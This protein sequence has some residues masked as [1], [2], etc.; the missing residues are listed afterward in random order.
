M[1]SP[2]HITVFRERVIELIAPRGG[3]LYVD[4]TLGLG[5][6]SEAILEASQPDGRVVCI[7]RDPTAIARSKARLARFGDRAEFHHA[8]M[9]SVRSVLDGRLVDGLVADLGVSSPQLD[10]PERGMS[11]RAEGPLD[12]RMDLDGEVTAWS[13]VRDLRESDLA[14]VIYQ[15]GEERRSRPIA[16]SIKRAI[17][18][19]EMET[20]KQLAS[21]IYRVMGPPRF[22]T[23]DPATRTFQALRIAVNDELGEL[24][25]LLAAV[26]DV[27]ADGGVAAIISF[28]SLE[29]RKVKHAFRDADALEV[30]TKKPIEPGDDECRENPRARSAKLR[31]ARRAVRDGEEEA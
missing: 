21:A 29:D 9:S 4:V 12:M 2:L 11:F 16:R 10:E 7:D 13:L 3:G 18:A 27:L 6:H 26:P 14:D 5:G 24:D 8:T 1:E 23:L 22:G 25:K 31:A 28:H 30:M 15:Y 19:G 17:E 20:T